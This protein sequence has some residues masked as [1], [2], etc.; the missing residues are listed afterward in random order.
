[1][2]SELI[3]TWDEAPPTANA[4]ATPPLFLPPAQCSGV[5]VSD[6]QSGVALSVETLCDSAVQTYSFCIQL[7][8]LPMHT[9]KAGSSWVGVEVEVGGLVQCYTHTRSTSLKE[10]WIEF[11][12]PQVFR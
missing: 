7:R 10:E 2:D 5:T 3:A 12:I 9:Q 4:A 1:M 8:T 11:L 6:P